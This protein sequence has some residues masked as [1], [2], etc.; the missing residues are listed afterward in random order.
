MTAATTVSTRPL[1]GPPRDYRFPY[2]E[3]VTLD[4]GLGVIVAPVHK[5]PIVSTALVVDAGAA[6]DPVD[7]Y[8]VAQLAA[9]LLLEGTR[10]RNGDAVSEQFER[11][12]AAVGAAAD[13]DA[14]VLSMTVLAPHLDDAMAL[15]AEV[16]LE[17][18]FPERELSRLKAERLSDLL[19]LRTEP[20][21]LADEMFTRFVYDPSSRYAHPESG[22]VTSVK[23]LDRAAVERFYQ[24]RYRPNGSTLIIVGDIN[25]ADGVTLA[26]R[27]LGEWTGAAAP[28]TAVSDAPARTTRAVHIVRKE[29]APQSE[30]RVGH[31][32]L[33]RSHPDYF[34]ALIVNALLGGLFSSRINLNLRE[35][36][37][38]TYGAHS[39]FDW[40]KAAGPFVVSTAVKSDVTADAAKEILLEISRIRADA[41]SE[42]ELTLATSYLDG[43]F[44]IRYETTD[45]IARALAALTIYGLP[46]DYFDSYRANIRRVSAMDVLHAADKYLHPDQLQ[47]VVVGDP[48]VIA[49]QLA[50][51]DAGPVSVYDADGRPE[52]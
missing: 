43:V 23:A 36:H 21:G 6:A 4:N 46:N 11:W 47:L 10:K 44:P 28:A 41:V 18:A 2:F 34:P 19:Q 7:A 31:V 29:E 8:G 33:P 17:P 37:A 25:V 27:L 14:A 50:A 26:Q 16:L 1:A 51:L 22:D 49:A 3:R 30:I 13:W 45:S 20:R 38:Y 40:R 12:G 15:F 32:G 42:D 9:R 5:L 24:A 35:V 39:S 48:S 52:R